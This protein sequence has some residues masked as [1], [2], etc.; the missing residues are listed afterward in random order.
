[1]NA[2]SSFTQFL[3]GNVSL[4]VGVVMLGVVF[5]VRAVTTDKVLRSDLRHAFFLFFTFLVLRLGAW[6]IGDNHL[7][8]TV[9]MLLRLGWMLTFAF[10]A[11]R[12]SVSTV[13]WVLR[14]R[15]RSP[16][17]KIV[18]DFINVTL[19]ALASLPI[20]KATLKIDLASL[21][22]TSAI[23]SVVIGLAMQDTLGNLFAGLSVQLERPFEVG[24]WVTVGK[25]SG[26]IAQIGWRATRIETARGE[27]VTLPNNVIAKEAVVNFTR[28]SQPI[29]TDMSLGVAYD[30]PPNRV[31]GVVL[32][33][34]REISECLKDPTPICRTT[35]FEDN[36]VKYLVR[37]FAANLSDAVT[38][39]EQ[40]HTR[41]WYRFQQ[42]GIEIPFP[43][44]VVHVRNETAA[45]S[46]PR[47][48]DAL[49]VLSGVD[50]LALFKTE[51]L[52]TL[53]N[54]VLPR[55]FAA[56]EQVIREG[57]AGNTFY[58][59]AQ[60]LVSVRAGNPEVE[61]TQLGPSQY[62]GEM[63]L[64][65]GEPRS[66]SVVVSRDALLYEITRPTFARILGSH[67]ELATALAD[68]LATRRSE[69]KRAANA[70]GTSM[71]TVNESRRIFARLKDLFGLADP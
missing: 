27:S 20:I 55:R 11:I 18:R 1:M 41:L 63:S 32:D 31:K 62:F 59:V 15:R 4:V 33:T 28:G 54:E 3:Q 67:P 66:A 44:R 38:V 51:D 5:G 39:N 8:A 36:A 6:A 61:V 26:N 46:Q 7:S 58:V 10:G 43:Q 2:S 42:E 71:E 48:D 21:V 40:L 70:A 52:R 16:L 65:T 37:F 24:D 22:A 9:A 45:P 34:L 35:A 23:L 69:L 29:G 17:P 30:V 53:A 19:Y 50:L 64:L 12:A 49:A 68:L 56:G 14:L 57:D 13:L 47:S 60:G 25:H